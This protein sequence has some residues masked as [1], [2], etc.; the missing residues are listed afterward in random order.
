MT[1]KVDDKDRNFKNI[2]TLKT[3]SNFMSLH[4]IN[5]KQLVSD[6]LSPSASLKNVP[7]L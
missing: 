4:L 3:Q 1:N 7:N 6:K 5:T 2:N